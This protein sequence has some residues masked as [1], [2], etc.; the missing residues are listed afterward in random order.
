MYNTPIV[1]VIIPCYNYGKYIEQAIQSIL[2]QSYKNWEIIV[3]DDGS[4][5]EYTIEKLEELK[6]KYAV[7]KI[8][9]SGPAVARNVGIEAAKGKFILPLD[10]D[11]TIHSDY[12]LEAIAAYEKNHP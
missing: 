8:D 7:I 4:D 1:S 5:D 2:E 10:S 11:D 3:V 12:L 9:R 6:K